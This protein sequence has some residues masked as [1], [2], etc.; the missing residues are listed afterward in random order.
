MT[1]EVPTYRHL[2]EEIQDS[3]VNNLAHAL[4]VTRSASESGENA[5]MSK[6]KLAESSNLSNGTV[7][8]LTNTASTQDAKPDL[9]TI[10]KLAFALNISPAFLLMTARDWKFIL[11][12]FGTLKMLSNPE[13]EREKPLIEI[14]AY[15]ANA[16]SPSE[17]AKKGLE[18]ITELRG[19]DYSTDE[20]ENQKKGIL[21]LTALGQ[22]AA[23]RDSSIHKMEAIALGAILGDRDLVLIKKP[24]T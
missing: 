19:D 7:T 1:P 2:Y 9:V 13:G 20:R 12:A 14:L 15:A 18:F 23:K 24:Q 17:A 11:Q 10:C 5:H 22:L 8:K 21:A 16:Q 3:F 4:R 6:G